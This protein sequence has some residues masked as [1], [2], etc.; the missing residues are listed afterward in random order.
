MLARNNKLAFL[1]LAIILTLA[2][3]VK[4][5]N[6]A[7]GST[8]SSHMLLGGVSHSEQLPP[9]PDELKTGNIFN[10]NSFQ[11]A[12]PPLQKAPAVLPAQPQSQP[13]PLPVQSGRPL[14]PHPIQPAQKKKPATLNTSV[15][16]P[17]ATTSQSSKLAIKQMNAY[18]KQQAKLGNVGTIGLRNYTQTGQTTLQALPAVTHSKTLTAAASSGQG[19][20]KNPQFK[21]GLQ[22]NS[23]LKRFQI[24]AWLAGRWAR[25][26]STEL[27]RVELPGKKVLKAT[28][29]TTTKVIDS[30]GTY[31]DS[32]GVIWQIFD[33]AQTSGTV[34]RGANIDYHTVSSYNLQATSDKQVV[35]TLRATHVVVSKLTHR[36]V[37]SYQDEELN[38]FNRINATRLRTDS[39][40]KVFNFKG[41]PTLLTTANSFENKIES[42]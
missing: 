6:T 21:A 1:M 18:L 20:V 11:S 3:S 12:P 27:S 37:A 35:V 10:E 38:C 31:R 16:T 14:A 8:T 42:P 5:D 33:P 2:R 25:I 22:K 41:K 28:G 4:A 13:H 26:D 24:P 36:I 32:K 15:S 17:K 40:T 7:T 30:F 23:N 19:T 9:L 39:S 34:D 29:K